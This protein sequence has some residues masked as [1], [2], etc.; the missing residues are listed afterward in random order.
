MQQGLMY[1]AIHTA[2]CQPNMHAAGHTP[3]A[4][5]LPGRQAGQDREQWLQLQSAQAF[6]ML[7]LGPMLP[8]VG[9]PTYRGHLRLLLLFSREPCEDISHD[10]CE[11]M[12]Q[13][14]AL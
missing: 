11:Y 1:A 5:K 2:Q 14:S 10:P 8:N 13:P 4:P 12:L 9:G 7:L 6:G 3:H